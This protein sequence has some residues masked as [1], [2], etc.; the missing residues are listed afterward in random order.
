MTTHAPARRAR[1]GERAPAPPAAPRDA[2][3]EPLDLTIARECPSDPRELVAGFCRAL[4]KAT[5]PRADGSRHLDGC[6]NARVNSQWFAC[7]DECTDAQVLL[8]WGLL[9]LA[10]NA[11]PATD[12]A[13]RRALGEAG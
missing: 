10:R 5:K 9:W 4:R 13:P 1:G 7:Q 11:V 12:D 3:R 6:R 8:V 2:A